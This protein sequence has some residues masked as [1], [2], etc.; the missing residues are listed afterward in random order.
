MEVFGGKPFGHLWI[1]NLAERVL[2]EI[3]HHRIFP[4]L[5]EI[6]ILCMR[7]IGSCE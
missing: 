7:T 4:C 6:K 1:D 3:H 5:D 2:L